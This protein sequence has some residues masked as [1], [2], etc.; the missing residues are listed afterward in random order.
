MARRKSRDYADIAPIDSHYVP[1]EI[2]D[3]SAQQ[4]RDSLKEA[5]FLITASELQE[6]KIKRRKRHNAPRP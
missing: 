4:V 2:A 6:R 3:T 1:Q 5:P